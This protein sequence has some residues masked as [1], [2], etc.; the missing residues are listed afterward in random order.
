VYYCFVT[1][2]FGDLISLEATQLPVLST[3]VTLCFGLKWHHT[4]G[5]LSMKQNLQHA[6]IFLLEKVFIFTVSQFS[7]LTL[8]SLTFHVSLRRS[9]KSLQM[10]CC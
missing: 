7:A 6:N 9:E 3:G 5:F 4:G 10:L 1:C 2:T 8:T